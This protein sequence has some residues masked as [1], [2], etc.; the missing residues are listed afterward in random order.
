MQ[1]FFLDLYRNGRQTKA[2]TTTFLFLYDFDNLSASAKMMFENLI[3]A[4]CPNPQF[5]L[6]SIL[7]YGDFPFMK[8]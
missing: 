7:R 1:L 6:H 2:T 5:Y 8:C 4:L 3:Y